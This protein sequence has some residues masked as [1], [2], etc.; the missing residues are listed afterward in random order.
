MNGKD[1]GT[2]LMPRELDKGGPSEGVEGGT[3][4]AMGVSVI[5]EGQAADYYFRPSGYTRHAWRCPPLPQRQTLCRGAARQLISRY[6]CSNRRR[7]RGLMPKEMLAF[8]SRDA[9]SLFAAKI[10]ETPPRN[11]LARDERW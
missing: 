7:R 6:H 1:V 9:G 8:L 2:E 3:G 11:H 10:A 4:S 5:F